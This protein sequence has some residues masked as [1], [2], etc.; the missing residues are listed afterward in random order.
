MPPACNQW[1]I[2]VHDNLLSKFFRQLLVRHA[3]AVP[4]LPRKPWVSADVS[5][6]LL[7][8][9]A[10]RRIFRA[11]LR[12][13][14]LARLRVLFV[15]WAVCPRSRPRALR[16]FPRRRC[17]P[18]YPWPEPHLSCIHPAIAEAL[19]NRSQMW[20]VSA[21]QTK[22][23][24]HT[25]RSTKTQCQLAYKDWVMARTE[26]FIAEVSEANPAPVWDLAK[27]LKCSRTRPRIASAPV[28]DKQR[29]SN[30]EQCGLGP[31]V[32]PTVCGGIFES[33]LAF[34]C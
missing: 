8:H 16:P 3:T 32:A 11:S 22:V 6:R 29:C 26:E 30:H 5:K 14:V 23:L 13:L 18:R 24:R 21:W 19:L 33:G 15:A 1:T 7:A 4:G 12:S 17:P 31:F 2:D 9:A 27:R 10:A 25:A 20:Q 34:D 28:L